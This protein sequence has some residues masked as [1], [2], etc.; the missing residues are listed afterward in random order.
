MN[1]PYSGNI[2]PDLAPKVRCIKVRK[3]NHSQGDFY[4]ELFHEHIPER[5]INNDAAP[6]LLKALVL[7]FEGNL[8]AG[9]I[10]QHYLNNLGK[11]PESYAYRIPFRVVY[12]ELGVMR[13]C[14][15]G[16]VE[17]WIDTVV[18]PDQFRQET[19]S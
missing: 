9:H 5:R 10:L 15:G 7:K 2:C 6:E 18:L 17:A 1:A 4:S 13:K 8:E 11:N 3:Y 12:P 16:D 14:C 19:K